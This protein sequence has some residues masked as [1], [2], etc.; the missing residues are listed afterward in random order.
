MEGQWA[1]RSHWGDWFPVRERILQDAELS[2]DTLLLVDISAG[3]GHDLLEFKEMFPDLLGRLVLEDLGSVVKA[4][5]RDE[6]FAENGI[7]MVSF[8]FFKEIQPVKD[9]RVYYFKFVLHDWPD[10]EVKVILNNLKPAMKP[11]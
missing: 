9:A 6:R 11:G 10:E 8:D 7:Q 2:D 4:M 5:G 1:D 3:K